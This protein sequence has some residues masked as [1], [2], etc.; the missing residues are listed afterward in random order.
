MSTQHEGVSADVVLPS[1]FATDDL[2]ERYAPYSLKGQS[3][4]PFMGPPTQR[5][6]FFGSLRSSNE[7]PTWQR[8]GDDLI[9]ELQRRSAERVAASEVFREIEE[10]LE[11]LR[12]QDD[13]IH[14]AEL[15]REREEAERKD[16]DTS[17][18]TGEAASG[19]EG[20]ETKPSA[21]PDAS[22]DASKN[23]K[24]GATPSADEEPDEDE[25][26]PQQEEALRILADLVELQ[27]TASSSW[28]APQSASRSAPHS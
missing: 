21:A 12:A 27:E 23:G 5:S 10:K 6:S 7:S 22:P 20:G 15:I 28:H 1:L 11:K 4:S 9:A 8:I 25:P 18:E 17:D 26:T 2:G 13:V 16:S 19:E 3:I 24:E 14:L